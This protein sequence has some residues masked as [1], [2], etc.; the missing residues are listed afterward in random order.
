MAHVFIAYSSKHRDL[1][2]KPAAQGY[3]VWWD[4][5]LES[6]G[7]YQKQIDAAL[8]AAAAVVVVWSAA[9]AASTY[10]LAETKKALA[11]SRLVNARAPDFP[12]SAVP[13]PYNA[14]HINI[15]DLADARLVPKPQ[16]GSLLGVR[17]RSL[18]A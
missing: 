10:V 11:A 13:T 6:W 12:T 4:Y 14:L 2:E 7:S 15:L 8:Q 17:N 3:S 18:A 5:E 1:T 16:P 9:A